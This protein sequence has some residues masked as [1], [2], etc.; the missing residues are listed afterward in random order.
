[1][2]NV[3]TVDPE[4]FVGEFDWLRDLRNLHTSTIVLPLTSP[5]QPLIPPTKKNKQKNPQS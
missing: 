4:F 5:P 3:K 1:M 2:V